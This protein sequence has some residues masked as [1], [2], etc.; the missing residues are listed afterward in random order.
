M[1]DPIEWH[2][3][4]VL[5][6][7]G[8]TARTGIFTSQNGMTADFT[9]ELCRSLF[10][11]SDA[12]SPLYLTHEDR[13]PCGYIYKLGYNSNTDEVVYEG[14]VFDPAKQD[15]VYA[16]G[17]DKL[18]PE[19][20]WEFDK[21]TKKPIRGKITGNAFVIDPAIRGNTVKK[22]FV[23]FSAPPHP[24]EYG[25]SNKAWSRPSLNDF[26]SLSWGELSDKEKKSIAGHFAYSANMPP[27]SFGELKFPHHDPKTHAIV[28]SALSNSLARL[29]QA[30]ISE[31]DKKSVYSHIARHYDEF[32][33]EPPQMYGEC[34]MINYTMITMEDGSYIIKPVD[35]VVPE[36]YSQADIGV[37]N[38]K[39]IELQKK[40][41][42]YENPAPMPAAVPAE[43]VVPVVPATNVAVQPV[44]TPVEQKADQY[45]E[46]YEALLGVQVETVSNEL[47]GLGVKDP[48]VIGTGLSVEQRL[49]VLTSVKEN[50]V[51][52]TPTITT[53]TVDIQ[54]I[55]IQDKDSKLK[56]M[57]VENGIDLS[58]LKY[59][60][61]N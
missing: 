24:W 45:K 22:E 41:E 5:K 21:V 48:S 46:K 51:K 18:S 9:P 57:M 35:T 23:A 50:I 54:T 6:V 14:F 13:E 4:K 40:V 26:T 2:N 29:K 33:K 16:C 53:E 30:N 20:E 7:S 12:S 52:T 59:V 34:K 36:K 61:V 47:K 15:K 1:N 25:K 38:E 58:N 19:I 42:N 17:Y 3:A 10:S 60:K 8:S 43:P 31:E 39:I 49:A 44:T 27:S 32:N 37:L 56:S 55:P 28:W 11:L